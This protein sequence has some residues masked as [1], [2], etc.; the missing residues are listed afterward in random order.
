MT[1][2]VNQGDRS[3]NGS[4]PLRADVVCC[5]YLRMFSQVFCADAGPSPQLLAFLTFLHCALLEPAVVM[6]RPS[7]GQLWWILQ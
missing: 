5:G 3:A 7:S 1:R 6:I 2:A 4:T